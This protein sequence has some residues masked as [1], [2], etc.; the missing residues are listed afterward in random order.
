MQPLPSGE[1]LVKNP[2]RASLIAIARSIAPTTCV[3]VFP[4]C[5]ADLA[6]L[7]CYVRPLSTV[8]YQNTS[9]V[10]SPARCTC[11]FDPFNF[12]DARLFRDFSPRGGAI[13]LLERSRRRPER[14]RRNL[15]RRGLQWPVRRRRLRHHRRYQRGLGLLLGHDHCVWRQL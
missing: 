4:L 3:I 8:V 11:T 12:I 10:T 13:H 15:L 1:S 5:S 6:F 7:N 2:A 9:P 14:R